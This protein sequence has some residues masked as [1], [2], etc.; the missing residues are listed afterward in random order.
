MLRWIKSNDKPSAG[1]IEIVTVEMMT[2]EMTDVMNVTGLR[3]VT[4]DMKTHKNP[5]LRDANTGKPVPAAKPTVGSKPQQQPQKPADK[6]AKC[7]L[8]G[9]KWIVVSVTSSSSSSSLQK[10]T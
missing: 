8:E 4:D 1:S 9:K 3:K 7:M 10:G 5:T 6:P 2:L